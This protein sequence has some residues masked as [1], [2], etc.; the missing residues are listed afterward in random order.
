ME[1]RKRIDEFV[2]NLNEVEIQYLMYTLSENF[3]VPVYL[4][5]EDIFESWMDRFKDR[6]LMKRY[7]REEKLSLI[8]KNEE[9]GQELKDKIYEDLREFVQKR[10]KY[11]DDKLTDLI[12]MFIYESNEY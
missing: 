4:T 6:G 5:K 3:I 8:M 9:E 10:S 12:D 1:E 11:I 2:Q 7:E